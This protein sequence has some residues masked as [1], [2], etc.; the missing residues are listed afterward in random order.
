MKIL[1]NY[2]QNCTNI[3]Q[4][5]TNWFVSYVKMVVCW[6]YKEFFFQCFVSRCLLVEVLFCFVFGLIYMEDSEP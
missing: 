4:Y 5:L 2:N 1:I 3:I 6:Q